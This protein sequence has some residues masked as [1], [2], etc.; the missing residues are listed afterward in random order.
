VTT[1]CWTISAR[2]LMAVQAGIRLCQALCLVSLALSVMACGDDSSRARLK[3]FDGDTQGT[4]YHIK[5]VDLPATLSAETVR[6]TIEAELDDITRH[7][8]T[9]EPDTELSR[10]NRSRDTGWVPA[11]T[12]LVQVLSEARRIS[13][14]SH[15]AYDVTVGPLVNL[16]GFGPEDTGERIPSEAEI[17]AAQT[18]IGYTHLSIRPSPPAIRKD[19]PDL[20]IDV[21]SIA[22]GYTVD[23]VAERLD[24]LG[25]ANY[26]VEIGGELRGKGLNQLGGHWRIGIERPTPGERSVYTIIRIADVG[27]STSGDYR[28]YFERDGHRYSHTI[29]PQTGR[30]VSHRLASVTVV[31]EDTMRAD[32]LSTALMVL[33]PEEGYHLA[34][35]AA[36]AA[37]FIIKSDGGFTD[38]ETTAF[39]R[40]RL[41]EKN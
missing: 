12:G 15:G 19:I 31:S 30:P 1:F 10:F 40:H 11:S 39:D 26:L 4:T 29:N 28:D 2:E 38:R 25:I 7:L 17:A 3:E 27:V 9:Y 23:R 16:W 24:S 8:S 33:G 37:Y 34:E 35:Q 6:T 41:K 14:L 36:I 18:L 21:A 20:T 5:V 22:Q 32:A 13:E